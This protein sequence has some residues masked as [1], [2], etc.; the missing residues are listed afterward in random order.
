MR[1]TYFLWT[2]LLSVSIALT[3]GLALTKAA[4]ISAD[5]HANIQ[6]ARW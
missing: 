6:K 2:G 4:R 5:I 3:A 1:L